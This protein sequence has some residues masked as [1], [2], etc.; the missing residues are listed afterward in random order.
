MTRVADVLAY[1]HEIAPLETGIPD[2][3]YGLVAGS[4]DRLV[5]RGGV[6]W[7]PDSRVLARM[8]AD[9]V[10]IVVS[11]EHLWQWDHPSPWYGHAVPQENKPAQIRRRAFFRDTG[12]AAIRLHSPWDA[13]R[14]DG[15]TDRCAAWLGLGERLAAEKYTAVYG[16]PPMTLAALTRQISELMPPLAPARLFGPPER[17]VRRVGV[18]I[19]GFGGNQWNIAEEF[20]Y[21][22]AEVIVFGDMV[23]QLALNALELN[24]PVIETLH[25]LSEEPGMRVLCDLLAARFPEIDWRFYPSGI[26]QYAWTEQDAD[27]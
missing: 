9:G 23:E 1:I 12:A 2:D 16:V 6:C 25:S 20:A 18:A 13:R 4:E 26:S 14:D 24:I 10:D 19:G 5:R 7:L 15:I 21:L 3:E 27:Q 17:I 8:A 11:H 22:G